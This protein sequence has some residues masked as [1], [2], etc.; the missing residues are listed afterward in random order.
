MAMFRKTWYIAYINF[1]RWKS[2]LRV[3]LIFAFLGVFLIQEIKGL[4]E[5][6]LE[7][8][9]QCTAFLLPIL[10]HSTMISIGTMKMM[11]YL[12]CI[13]LLC[14]APFV[15]KATPYMVLRS[16]RESWWMGECLY[17]IL[18]TFLYTAFITLVSTLVVLPVATFG[19]S[20]GGVISALRYGSEGVEGG[21]L[22]QQY[23]I[24]LIIPKNTL[25]YL[26]P[27]GAQM[28]TFLTVWVSFIVLGLLQYLV[29]LVSKSMF[30]GFACTG[31]LVFLDPILKTLS[32]SSMFRWATRLSPV[33]WSS[34]EA[35]EMVDDSK[36][37]TIPYVVSM[38]AIL[39]VVLL[40]AIHMVSRKIMIEVRGEV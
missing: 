24:Y 38:F 18:T 35:L 36:V 7:T 6:G 11:L 25:G 22:A 29:S 10:F 32:E 14:D 31:V 40:V 37:L 39:I 28:Y 26:Y 2:D 33:C 3:W 8:G 23:G 16:Q 34:T 12:G 15:Y 27:A 13:L 30:L 5:Y 1:R 21:I 4:T 20:W 17:I 19:E 9:T